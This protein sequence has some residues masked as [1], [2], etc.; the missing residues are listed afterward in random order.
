MKPLMLLSFLLLVMLS[1]VNAA[2]ASSSNDEG[3]LVD[4]PS[5]QLETS[6][7]LPASDDE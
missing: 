6:D 3:R 2:P 7:D 4:A 1:I 5:S